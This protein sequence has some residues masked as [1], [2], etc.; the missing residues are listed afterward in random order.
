MNPN[1]LING[2]AYAAFV[3]LLTV[4]TVFYVL[5]VILDGLDEKRKATSRLSWWAAASA[6]TQWM[7]APGL[8]VPLVTGGLTAKTLPVVAG[9]CLG[10]LNIFISSARGGLFG[11]LT[12]A[13]NRG[14]GS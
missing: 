10:I 1:D 11:S 2:A 6:G 7:V 8:L 14:P 13:G 3:M 9:V 5:I 4:G 12:F